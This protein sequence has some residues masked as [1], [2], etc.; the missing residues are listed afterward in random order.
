[1]IFPLEGVAAFQG[2]EVSHIFDDTKA[3]VVPGRVLAEGAG[4]WVLA[5]FHKITALGTAFEEF[6]R[7]GEGL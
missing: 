7:L 4:G 3:R 2:V 6:S 5:C 1:M